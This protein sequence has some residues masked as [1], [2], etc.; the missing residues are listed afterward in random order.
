VSLKAGFILIL[1]CAL[2]AS[3]ARAQ[4]ADAAAPHTRRQAFADRLAAV[5]NTPAAE[6]LVDDALGNPDPAI[7]LEALEA[8]HGFVEPGSFSVGWELCDNDT[9]VP[10]PSVLGRLVDRAVVRLN[11]ASGAVRA[12]AVDILRAH[13]LV[14][15]VRASLHDD[16]P[17]VRLAS[18]RIVVG[19]T[20]W[21]GLHFATSP[22]DIQD[23]GAP[24]E[25]VSIEDFATELDAL[26]DDSDPTIQAIALEILAARDQLRQ[27][28]SRPPEVQADGEIMVPPLS[29]PVLA[30]L[31]SVPPTADPFVRQVALRI[32][33]HLAPV[34]A[35]HV[36]RVLQ[37][38]SHADEQVGADAPFGISRLRSDDALMAT[39]LV[40]VQR[41]DA[42]ARREAAV[43]LGHVPLGERARAQLRSWAEKEREVL[44]L[45]ELRAA[46]DSPREQK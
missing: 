34:D 28:L 27:T 45:Q 21:S 13:D 30:R 16:D 12:K 37:A 9:A 6:A 32:L 40:G 15:R 3:P 43:A 5:V 20:M 23:A 14:P 7:R 1:M 24:A 10:P 17:L 25:A 18:L 19:W 39:L 31:V 8:I 33:I 11:D 41:L 38:L 42:L 36:T 22:Y 2:V 4:D 29:A 35:S 26:L 44:V 46:L